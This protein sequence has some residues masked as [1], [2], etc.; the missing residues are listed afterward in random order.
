MATNNLLFDVSV[1]SFIFSVYGT[2]PLSNNLLGIKDVY[3]IETTLNNVQIMYDDNHQIIKMLSKRGFEINHFNILKGENGGYLPLFYENTHYNFILKYNDNDS[4]KVRFNGSDAYNPEKDVKAE[5]FVTGS[6]N[7]R[8]N[9]GK[10]SISILKNE[11]IILTIE[12]SVFSLKLDY[13]KDRFYM[14]K[15]LQEVNT[16]I[17]LNIFKS[18][19]TNFS[20]SKVKNNSMIEWLNNYIRVIN[21]LINN[22]RRIEKRAFSHLEKIELDF[23]TS[24]IRSIDSNVNSYLIKFGKESLKNKKNLKLIGNELTHKSDELGYIKYL[25]EILHKNL[26]KLFNRIEASESSFYKRVSN[27]ENYKELKNKSSSYKKELKKVFWKEIDSKSSLKNRTKF[28][29]QKDFISYEKNIKILNRV[30]DIEAIGENDISVMTMDKLYE[31]WIYIKLIDIISKIKGENE[32]LKIGYYEDF[33]KKYL[34]IGYSN[35]NKFDGLTVTNNKEYNNKSHNFYSPA[36]PQIPDFSI[37]LQKNN[38][39]VIF[40]SKYKIQLKALINNKWRVLKN[41]DLFSL[42][43]DSIEKLVIDRKDEDINTMHRY[44]DAIRFKNNTL[45][46]VDNPIKYAVILYPHKPN[47]IIRES[48]L[49]EYSSIESNGV[50]AVPVAPGKKDEDWIIE[51]EKNKLIPSDENVE[52]IRILAKLINDFIVN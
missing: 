42:D 40:D 24:K 33:F 41:Y 47:E 23:P 51:I 21:Q 5:N 10:S 30:I 9:V 26:N 25:T 14:L 28:N 3:N 44:R 29:F 20:E 38:R 45:E 39:L 4:Y 7:F 19:S 2:P 31:S 16:S 15:E 27:E 36:V 18:T 17:V 46:V 12:F 43:K 50:G 1:N 11:Q 13:F 8:E 37:E 35:P 49:N 34:A 22:L 52:Q 6:F 32:E 48:Y